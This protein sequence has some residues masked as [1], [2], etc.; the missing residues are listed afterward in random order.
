MIEKKRIVWADALKGILIIL[1]VLGHSIGASMTKLG[2]SFADDYLWNLIYSFHM[3]TFIAISGFLALRKNST[4]GG[5]TPW[6][7]T[8]WRRFRQLMIPFL[9]WSIAL[10]FVN[11]NVSYYYEYLQYPQKA[12]WFLWALFFIAIIFAGVDTIAIKLK[13]NQEVTMII[14]W[15][16]LVVVMFA[17]PDAKLFGVEYVAYYFFFYL[18]GYYL[19]KYSER[20]VIK[21]GLIIAFVGILWFAL[22]SIFYSQGLPK[23]L[24]FITIIPHSLLYYIYRITTAILA[25]FFLFS[26]LIKIFEKEDRSAKYIVQ[27]GKVSLGIYAV[28]MV[29]RFKLVDMVVSLIPNISYWPLMIITFCLL[30]LVSYCVV[31]ILGKWSVTATW[32]LGKLQ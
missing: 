5:I 17:M 32:L 6:H 29:I 15:T 3:P 24:Q 11:H 25:V 2:N 30:L 28:H 23:Q 7:S 26:L 10:F 12:L 18:L 13:I 27:I 14:C 8:M 9:L 20:L 21:R 19:H 16:L 31:W 22:G 4:G 1:V